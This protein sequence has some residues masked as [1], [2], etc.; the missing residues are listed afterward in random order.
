M[1]NI[2]LCADLSQLKA[3]RDFVA[4]A[5]RDLD[6]ED[7]II[8]DVQLAVDEI[9][10]NVIKHG[11]GGRGGEIEVTVEPIEDGVQVTVRDWGIA[12]DP[13]TVAVPNVDAPLELRSLGGL[14]LFL[15][16]QLMDNVRFEFDG[17]RGNSVTMVKRLRQEGGEQ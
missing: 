8:P 11:Y 15:V 17:E 4:E 12:F 10:S 9:C 2:R 6:V 5:S 14:G 16:R 13:Q 1:A 7:W 3:I